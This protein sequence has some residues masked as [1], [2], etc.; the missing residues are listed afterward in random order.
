MRYQRIND[1]SSIS[2]QEIESYIN[3]NELP[4]IQF[5]DPVYED[6]LLESIN[7]LCIEYGKKI[8]VRFYGHYGE[9][10][11]ANTLTKL[12]N[13]KNLSVDCLGE[14]KNV[15]A[16]YRLTEL[17]V[18]SF[19]VFEFNDANFLS[20]LNF[21]N[22][23]ELSL[24]DNRKKNFDLAFLKSALTLKKLRL[25]GHNK[26]ICVLNEMPNLEN[27]TL[28]Q[29]GK[30]IS[31]SFL[32]SCKK[33]KELELILGGRDNINDINIPSLKTLKILRVRGFE[34]LGDLSRFPN[35]Q[36]LQVEDQIKLESINFYGCFLEGIAIDNCKNLKK[37]NE[38]ES[39]EKLICFNVSRSA[40]D[41]EY[42]RDMNWPISVKV[43]SLWGSSN[44]WNNSCRKYL[45]NKGYL[46]YPYQADIQF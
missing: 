35:L 46:T 23:L 43:L 42:L 22:L 25:Y 20:H 16:L 28:G 9:G 31:L 44:K 6:S 24:I 38:L 13:V 5:C 27:L 21:E 3:S 32:S 36:Y 19:G 34:S 37:L 33:L 7:S 17:E 8:E 1:P 10:F 15:E 41:L 45:D 12:P 30:K 4:V 2:K 14:I 26:N 11:D 39:Q 18:L 29:I 40:L